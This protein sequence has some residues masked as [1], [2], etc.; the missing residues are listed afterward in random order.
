MRIDI[1][2][3]DYINVYDSEN[4]LLFHITRDYKWNS[5]RVMSFYNYRNELILKTFNYL[6]IPFRLEKIIFQNLNPK[7]NF[8]RKNGRESMLVI[9]DVVT[10]RH[11]FKYLISKKLCDIYI[12]NVQIANVLINKRFSIK[13]LIFKLNFLTNI[14]EEIKRLVC[15]L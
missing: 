15:L 7:I 6:L 10:I 14:K 4:K 11:N 2:L 9:D 12:N 13:N 1:K 5:K 3:H 8:I